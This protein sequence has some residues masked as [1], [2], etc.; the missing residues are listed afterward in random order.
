MSKKTLNNSRNSQYQ[1]ISFE[2]QIQNDKER[3]RRKF[4]FTNSNNNS[5]NSSNISDIQSQLSICSKKKNLN[6]KNEQ[7]IIEKKSE[8]SSITE[9][10]EE[11]IG[12]NESINNTINRKNNNNINNNNNTNDD[13]YNVENSER[14]LEF[15]II[16]KNNKSNNPVNDESIL[17]SNKKM[18][19]IGSS[20]FLKANN[21]FSNLLKDNHSNVSA[22]GLLDD[23]HI[24]IRNHQEEV[25]KFKFIHEV[26]KNNLSY[27]NISIKKFLALDN[28]CT[29]NI[30]SFLYDNYK[31]I[32]TTGKKIKNA[33]NL[34]LK[35]KF[36][37][38]IENFKSKYKEI[39][40][41][42][43]FKFIQSET[44]MLKKKK[45]PIFSIFFKCK[46]KET[47]YLLKY[48]GISY[49][50]TYSFKNSQSRN[51]DSLYYQIYKFDIR[52]NKYYPIW[53]CSEMDERNYSQRR[54]VYSSPVQ[55]YV[56]KD[57][58]ILKID[59]IE[60][61]NFI[62]DINFLDI[63]ILEAPQN[64]YEKGVFKSEIGYDGMRDC[65][66]ENMILRWNNANNLIRNSEM[67]FY[68]KRTFGNYFS[69]KD[70]KYD[71]SKI[72]FFKIKM[73]AEKVGL[74]KK[75]RIFNINLQILNETSEITNECIYIGCV[76]TFTQNKILQIRK[77][78]II[79]L[80]ITDLKS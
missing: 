20:P 58:I 72:I 53:I 71:I 38:I 19:R 65:E 27:E 46:I 45:I 59:L 25:S 12:N 64:L 26:L 70:I 8:K 54:L 24:I 76:N 15:D 1:I 6:N 78:T 61:N 50:I 44:I 29:F 60:G 23:E 55:N 73:Q 4:N 33:F 2:E 47:P 16:E 14:E 67:L 11:A 51:K 48:E 18:K 63:K 35:S 69:F 77:G 62:Y 10:I 80:Y 5:L 42:E 28:K 39:L 52:K 43:S 32:M 79:I 74:I 13:Y 57:H 66:I 21:K 9:I 41:F 49:E 30:F 40:Q 37:Y 56:E 3:I 17:N 7:I 22:L 36:S 34:T 31:I 68:I 75:N